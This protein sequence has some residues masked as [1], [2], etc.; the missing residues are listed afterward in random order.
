MIASGRTHDVRSLPT[1]GRN[2]VAIGNRKSQWSA[3]GD[4]PDAICLPPANDRIGPPRH[5]AQEHP[6]TPERQVVA[7]AELNRIR[8]V[9]GGEAPL[10]LRLVRILQ[11]R[12][13]SEPG[14][15]VVGLRRIVDRL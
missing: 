10:E 5:V 13:A 12:K 8:N 1:I 11:T 7:V 2:R 15:V 14:Y 3:I 9:E 6:S 4:A